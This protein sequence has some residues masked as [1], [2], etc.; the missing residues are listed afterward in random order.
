[1]S[2]QEEQQKSPAGVRADAVERVAAARK[3]V[4]SAHRF[5]EEV[6][7]NPYFATSH[8]ERQAEKS[9]VKAA[10]EKAAAELAAGKEAAREVWWMQYLNK[11]IEKKEA[12]ARAASEGAA[13]RATMGWDEGGGRKKYKFFKSK[14]IIKKYKKVKT[15]RKTKTKRKIK[16][17]LTKKRKTYK[18]R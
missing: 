18:K 13:T 5:E 11:Q 14:K 6:N 8:H 15:K 7:R 12:R 2:P 17:K 3:A 1:M 9:L 4:A 16:T 10:K